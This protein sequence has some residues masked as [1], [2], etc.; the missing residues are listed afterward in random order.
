MISVVESS[1]LIYETVLSPWM[2]FLP[3]FVLLL[4]EFPVTNKNIEALHV[5]TF[6]Y[7]KELYVNYKHL[8]GCLDF[9]PFATHH[10]F[11]HEMKMMILMGL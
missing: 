8:K 5:N 2:S 6:L 10:F 11:C 4:D 1:P 3:G 7:S 9:M